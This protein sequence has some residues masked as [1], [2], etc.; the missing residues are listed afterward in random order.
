MPGPGCS[1]PSH[2]FIDR[3]ASARVL[4][5]R[6]KALSYG[7]ALAGVSVSSRRTDAGDR[8]AQ[9]RGDTRERHGLQV[10]RVAGAPIRDAPPVGRHGQPA[11]GRGRA[12]DAP[13]R[14][15]DRRRCR[16]RGALAGRRRRDWFDLTEVA[17]LATQ[18][19]G[20]CRE[21]NRCALRLPRRR[22]ASGTQL[23]VGAAHRRWRR[24]DRVGVAC[25]SRGHSARHSARHSRA[26]RIRC[27]QRR[28]CWP[29]AGRYVRTP[30]P[31]TRR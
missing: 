9:R 3:W 26:P 12:A 8:S 11:L 17:G 2:P 27:R 20:D 18:R 5:D 15:R 22:F 23:H 28:I 1:P 19:R 7:T 4:R 30:T 13:F 24:D 21:G 16:R 31:R 10:R 25:R 29:A 6:C 14:W